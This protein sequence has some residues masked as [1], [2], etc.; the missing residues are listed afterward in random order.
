MT[1]VGVMPGQDMG[2]FSM[3]RLISDGR[4][5]YQHMWGHIHSWQGKHHGRGL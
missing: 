1:V 3:R 4:E 2:C 5:E